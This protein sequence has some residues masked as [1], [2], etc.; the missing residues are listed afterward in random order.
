MFLLVA[1][2][3]TFQLTA[4]AASADGAVG[5]DNLSQIMCSAATAATATFAAKPGTVIA[6]HATESSAKPLVDCV[7]TS[8]KRLGHAVQSN[9]ASEYS[10]KVKLGPTVVSGDIASVSFQASRCFA[11]DG[12]FFS[13]TSSLNFRRVDHG[14][15]TD[16]GL[17]S[18]FVVDGAM[19]NR[20]A[21]IPAVKGA[22]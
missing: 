11:E 3:A 7:R 20:K 1:V 16:D 15:W 5:T 2:M 6:V 13:Q 21:S 12:R 9:N 19:C 8:L 22:G 4:G 18:G 14:S 17:K 10:L